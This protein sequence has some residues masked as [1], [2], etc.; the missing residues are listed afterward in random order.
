MFL[1]HFSNT[2][3]PSLMEMDARELNFW[4]VEAVSLHNKL[5]RPPDG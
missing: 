1:A 4:H 3:I 2:P 5:N